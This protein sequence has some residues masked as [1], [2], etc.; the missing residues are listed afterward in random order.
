[1]DI[2]FASPAVAP[3]QCSARAMQVP[4]RRSRTGRAGRR[5][6]TSRRR[7]NPA[8]T[9]RFFGLTV[10]A[11]RSTGPA[12]PMPAPRSSPPAGQ[13][14]QG[15]VDDGA[16]GAPQV[17]PRGRRARG[18]AHPA[19]PDDLPSSSTRAAS[20]LVPP[21]STARASLDS[22]APVGDELVGVRST[23]GE[24]SARVSS[25]SR[26]TRNVSDSPGSSVTSMS[27][28]T[29]CHVDLVDE[30][31]QVASTRTRGH[32]RRRSRRRP[33][34]TDVVSSAAARAPSPVLDREPEPA[35]APDRRD[36]QLAGRVAEGADLGGDRD[37]DWWS[38]ASSARSTGRGGEHRAV[39][40]EPAQRRPA[41]AHASALSFDRRRRRA[42]R[43]AA[44]W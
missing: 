34:C 25:A 35:L 10:P 4:S 38:R 26:L 13:G 28:T 2:E 11:T 43:R 5:S 24:A 37:R 3:S 40:G 6:S 27:S 7:S 8:S 41:P 31:R 39:E 42:R 33:R 21:R 16:D 19:A 17:C 44:G 9:G 32:R 1:M 23:L 18:G 14:G 12:E 20:I 22:S 36:E 30:Q 15:T 29:A